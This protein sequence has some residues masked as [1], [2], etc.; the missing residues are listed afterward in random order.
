[1]K[2]S[3]NK[4]EKNMAIDQKYFDELTK[5]FDR[6][7]N[8]TVTFKKTNK[9][10]DYSNPLNDDALTDGFVFV[11]HDA[12][13]DKLDNDYYDLYP[14]EISGNI[15][16]DIYRQLLDAGTPAIVMSVID[17]VGFLNGQ[18]NENVETSDEKYVVLNAYHAY[19]DV[20]KF[21][22]R[23]CVHY[24]VYYYVADNEKKILSFCKETSNS[25]YVGK[26]VGSL[27]CEW[28]DAAVLSGGS[29]LRAGAYFG[30]DAFIYEKAVHQLKRCEEYL[31]HQLINIEIKDND[32]KR[33]STFNINYPVIESDVSAVLNRLKRNMMRFKYGD[34]PFFKK[35][36]TLIAKNVK[37]Y[38]N[39][40]KIEVGHGWK[41]EPVVTMCLSQH[42]NSELQRV[43]LDKTG[44]NYSELIKL[45][46]GEPNEFSDEFLEIIETGVY[47]WNSV[48]NIVKSAD[49]INHVTEDCEHGLEEA[50]A[51]KNKS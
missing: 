49:F 18:L 17:K 5:R 26:L 15:Y 46:Y 31:N 51:Q 37:E 25:E 43:L 6:L 28:R 23:I 11:K 24:N 10:S 32:T 20:E 19:K 2:K 33:R 40:H 38:V 13:F 48:R 21:V 50:F 3:R 27:V 29:E 16:Y 7:L 35:Y 42:L 1:M 36:V 9:V 8:V 44:K 41:A 12:E 39:E 14:F 30:L 34:M 47:S 22:D 45:V 4:S